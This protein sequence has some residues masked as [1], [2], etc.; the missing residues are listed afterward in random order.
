MCIVYRHSH[1][2][3]P[4]MWYEGELDLEEDKIASGKSNGGSTGTARPSQPSSWNYLGQD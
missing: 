4:N 2:L 1:A 3:I